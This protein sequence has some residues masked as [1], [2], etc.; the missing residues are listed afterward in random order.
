MARKKKKK[1]KKKTNIESVQ[2]RKVSQDPTIQRNPLLRGAALA[3]ALKRED[4]RKKAKKK[5]KKKS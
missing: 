3:E 5:K 1:A 4:R 2:R